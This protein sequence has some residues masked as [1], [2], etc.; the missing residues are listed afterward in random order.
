[1]TARQSSLEITP[2]CPL[3]LGSQS[4]RRSE[5]LRGL[6]VPIVV[7]PA[8]ADESRHPGEASE[9]YVARVA[10]LKLVAVAERLASEGMTG[11][12]GI[13][14]ADTTVVVDGDVLGKPA[15]AD[16]AVRMLERITG[17]AHRVL[18]H[19]AISRGDDPSRVAL[20]RTV[21]SDVFM[22]A[23]SA[24]EIR[25]YADTGEGLDKAGAYAV[26]G[27][28]AFLVE[29]ISGSYSN[30]VGLPA[31]ELIVDLTSLGLLTTFPPK[32]SNAR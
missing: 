26:Q 10:G 6:G 15:D 32:K 12:A 31:C 7:R 19:Y 23:A 17:R 2:E 24:S 14:V 22:R 27:I 25:S 29:K 18:T 3:V 30:V 16:D 13:V 8:D 4:P 5:I 28:G 20:S 9:A 1:M 11:F 21:R